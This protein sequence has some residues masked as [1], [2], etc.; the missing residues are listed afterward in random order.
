MNS[1]CMPK[2]PC[3]VQILPDNATIVC[4]D[5]FGDVYSLPL[6]EET[7]SSYK[8]STKSTTAQDAKQTETAPFKPSATSKTVHTQRNLKSLAAQ[9]TQQNLTPK[10]KGPLAFKHELLLGHVSMLTDLVYTSSD[11]EGKKRSYILTA[12]RDEHIRVSRGPPQ[13]H[14]IEGY[15]LGHKEFISKICLVPNTEL[16]ISGGGD[17]W[18]GVWDWLEFK[19]RQR[20]PLPAIDPSSGTPAMSGIYVMPFDA[21]QMLVVACERM[22]RLLFMPMDRLMDAQWGSADLERP[23]LDMM[24]IGGTV[25]VSLDARDGSPRRLQAYK[26]ATTEAGALLLISDSSLDHVLM[27]MNATPSSEK[28]ATQLDELL[29]GVEKLRKRG[30][31]DEVE[32]G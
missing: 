3:A 25:V 15:C 23:I 28:D 4:G 26:F 2:R 16:L 31:Q 8:D 6:I 10:T 32:D 14:V 1:R 19:L 13:S 20:L 5:K 12:D 21:G 29:Y 7:N 27:Q 24:S 30:V 9:Q 11:I 18:I 17:D 22:T